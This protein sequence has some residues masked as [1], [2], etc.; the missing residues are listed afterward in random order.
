VMERQTDAVADSRAD[1]VSAYYD[2]YWS[3]GPTPHYELGET[4]TEL[5]QGNVDSRTRCLDVGCGVGGDYGQWVKQRAASYV[6]VDVSPRAVEQARAAGLDAHVI[7]DAASLPFADESFDMVICIEVFEHLFSPDR[8]ASEIRRVLRPA[9]RLVASTPNAVYWRLRVNLL[10]GHWNPLG[11]AQ[12]VE[13]PWRD[14]HVRFFS[15]RTLARMLDEAGFSSIE[16]GAHGGRLLD[17][18]T[19]RPTDFGA[20]RAYRV[21]ERRFPALLGATLHALATR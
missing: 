19:S 11:D 5:V 6:G 2:R 10:F 12:A 15:P 1:A 20:S 16:V 3:V 9:G 7:D 21:L 4:L 14:P 13:R 18:L 8:A 17:H